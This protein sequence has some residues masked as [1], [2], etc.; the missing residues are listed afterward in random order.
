MNFHCILRPRP[1]TTFTMKLMPIAAI[2]VL[3]LLTCTGSIQAQDT[4]SRAA[5]IDKVIGF[6]YAK[7]DL[8][9]DDSKWL[10]SFMDKGC[11]CSGFEEKAKAEECTLALFREEDMPVDQAGFENM[12]AEQMRKFNLISPLLTSV[13]GKCPD[14]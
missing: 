6:V 12:T 14:K 10:K 7:A 5:W 11:D 9:P 2:T 4:L 13:G 1:K 3:A 8:D